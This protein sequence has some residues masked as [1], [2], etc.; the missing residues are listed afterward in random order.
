MAAEPPNPSF[1]QRLLTRLAD[2]VYLHPR[3]FFYPQV[4]LFAVCLLY[5]VRHLDFNTS[6]NDLV[7]SDKKYHQNFLAFKKEFPGQDDLVVIVE[8]DRMDKN[9]QFVDRLG[10]KLEAETNLFTDV[11][12][13]GDLRLMG[14]KALLMA[15][16]EDLGELQKK[17]KDYQQIGRAHV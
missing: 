12:Y 11:F 9:R 4:A 7:G 3:A 10:A 15:K 14:R 5:T 8:S 6:R 17:L 13:K 1:V 2:A 16:A